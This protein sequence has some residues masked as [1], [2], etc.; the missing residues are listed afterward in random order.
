MIKIVF[1]SNDLNSIRTAD[2]VS[3]AFESSEFKR[4]IVVELRDYNQ[5]ANN[6][7]ENEKYIE[8]K[9]SKSFVFSELNQKDLY[10]NLKNSEDQIEW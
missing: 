2:I 7:A 10:D 4:E 1:T 5:N 8:D 6:D 9:F 3:Q